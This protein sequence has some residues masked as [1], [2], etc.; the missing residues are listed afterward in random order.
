MDHVTVDLGEREFAAGIS[1]VALSRTKCFDSLRMVAFDFDRYRH[2]ENGIN[3]EARRFEFTRLRILALHTLQY[4]FPLF[5]R[6]LTL[7][8]TVRL[9]RTYSSL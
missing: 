2:F 4:V 8:L 7:T 3:V 6:A 5:E 9:T 1:F